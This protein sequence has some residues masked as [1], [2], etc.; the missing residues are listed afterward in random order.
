[1]QL[2]R[3]I[4]KPKTHLSIIRSAVPRTVNKPGIGGH[5]EPCT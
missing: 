2:V 1:L 4:E 5:S 3:T